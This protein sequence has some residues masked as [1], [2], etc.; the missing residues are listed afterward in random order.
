M[1]P[2]APE[3]ARSPAALS[4]DAE[5]LL[6]G[7]PALDLDLD[8]PISSGADPYRPAPAQADRGRFDL[9]SSL[10]AGL[11][12]I[13]VAPEGRANW[14]T[15]ITPPRERMTFDLNELRALADFGEP[16]SLGPLNAIYALRVAFRRR[17]LRHALREL[18][19]ELA[20][21][22]QARN[23]ELADL[24]LLLRSE[25]EASEAFRRLLSPLAGLETTALEQRGAVEQKSAEE[26]AELAS[27]DAEARPINQA[28]AADQAAEGELAAILVERE[29]SVQRAEARYKRNQ[30]EIRGLQGAPGE[31]APSDAAE[32]LGHLQA[33][34]E[35]LQAEL[36]KA[37]RLFE[38]SRAEREFRKRAIRE[39]TFRLGELERRRQRVRAGYRKELDSHRQRRDESERRYVAALA[40]VGRGV[41]AT[42]GG[43]SVDPARL[44]A[45]RKAD[46]R[47]L[48]LAGDSER[49]LRALDACDTE[50]LSSGYA[51]WAGLCAALVA[52]ITYKC[53]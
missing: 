24:A 32:R 10:P 19:A 13:T 48:A 6:L 28:L 42:R 25:L 11:A 1:A 45:L 22:E 18:D 15:G 37:K 3:A 52:F 47:V 34:S 36:D 17:A 12:G 7:G 49:H 5:E 14:P 33:Q 46:A 44:E 41:L 30:L 39:A 16:S 4:S 8:S 35:L 20:S 29:I 9:D 53:L 31:A 40:D 2:A 51:W 26:L 27:I 21:A 23:S 38:A 43:V 50:K